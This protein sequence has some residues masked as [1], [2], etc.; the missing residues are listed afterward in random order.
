MAYFFRVSFFAC[1]GGG[2][3]LLR[4]IS[5]PANPSNN[6]RSQAIP[7]VPPRTPPGYSDR[8]WCHVASLPEEGVRGGLLGQTAER[9]QQVRISYIWARHR[10]RHTAAAARMV[11]W[12]K[13]T[14]QTCLSQARPRVGFGGGLK[15]WLGLCGRRLH[16]ACRVPRAAMLQP[17]SGLGEQ[18][19]WLS[20]VNVTEMKR[21]SGAPNCAEQRR[22]EWGERGGGWREREEEKK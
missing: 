16:P 10:D 4:G 17:L 8:L 5:R 13:S 1:L 6:V 9:L 11:F 14:R 20:F 15:S 3:R 22:R 21:E 2:G 19:G 12:N 18:R 7:A